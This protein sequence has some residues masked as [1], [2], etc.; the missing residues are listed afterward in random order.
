MS[1]GRRVVSGEVIGYWLKRGQA[2]AERLNRHGVPTRCEASEAVV[3][4][5][6]IVRLHFEMGTFGRIVLAEEIANALD[7]E[8]DEEVA[9]A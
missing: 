3:A 7:A 6:K 1:K 8:R 2:V 4:G 9:Q 5:K